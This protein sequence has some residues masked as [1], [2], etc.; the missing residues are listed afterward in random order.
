VRLP[1]VGRALDDVTL[2]ASATM[3]VER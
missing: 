2:S 3:R 1:L